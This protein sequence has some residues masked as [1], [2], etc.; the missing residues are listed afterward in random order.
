MIQTDL[1]GAMAK[2]INATTAL[3]TSYMAVMQSRPK[4]VGVVFIVAADKSK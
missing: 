2:K 4:D 3:P 1:E